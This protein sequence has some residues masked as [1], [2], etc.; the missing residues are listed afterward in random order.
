MNAQQLINQIHEICSLH[1]IN[2]SS[3]EVNYRFDYDSDIESV[4]AVFEDTYD[5]ETNSR[6]KSIMLVTDDSEK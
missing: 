2:P 6:L 5:A 3:L 4:K 1:E